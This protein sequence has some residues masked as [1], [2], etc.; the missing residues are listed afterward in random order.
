MPKTILSP[1]TMLKTMLKKYQLTCTSLAKDIKVS[2]AML[3]LIT[4][5]QAKISIPAAA[6]LAKYFNTVPE[7]WLVAQMK[8][9]LAGAAKDKSLQKTI[10]SI[11]KVAKP[12]KTKA[13]A[14]AKAAPK[15]KRGKAAPARGRRTAK[16]SATRRGK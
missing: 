15:Q 11:P 10:K 4:N 8:Y 1:G 12:V 5:D 3:R 14:K 13:K 7:Y 2:Y 6:K 16:S 9:D